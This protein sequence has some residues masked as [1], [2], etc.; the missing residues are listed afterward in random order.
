[1]SLTDYKLCANLDAVNAVLNEPED[2]DWLH[3]VR[4][5]KDL[6]TSNMI[7]TA[8]G[9][10]NIGFLAF[11]A[12]ALL[13]LF[14]G[15]PVLVFVN[16]LLGNSIFRNFFAQTEPID[17]SNIGPTWIMMKDAAGRPEKVTRS[18]LR[19][20]IDPDTPQSAMTRLS[21]DGTRR[22]K[23]VFSDEFNLDD[24]T[25]FEGDDP[26]WTA[27][28]LH[29]WGTSDYE[30]YTPLGATT[31]GGALRITLSEQPINNLNFKSAMLQ[32]W[33]KLCMQGGLLE[34]SLM[35][36]G[37]PKVPGYWPA[38]WTMS[39]LGR[40][41]FG[42]TNEGINYDSE[43]GPTARTVLPTADSPD[44]ETFGPAG[45][46]V[47][48]MPN[49][50]YLPE[51][52][53]GPLAAEMTG[54][55]V[56]TY[57]PALSFQPGQK[58]SRCTCAS[59]TDHPGPKHPD[60]S[61][62][63]RGASELDVLEATSG[64][65]GRN[66]MSLQTAPYNSGYNITPGYTRVYD[67]VNSLNTYTG[68]AYQ[69]AVSAMIQTP[70]TAYQHNGGEYAMYGV[71]W[72]PHYRQRDPYVTWLTANEPSWTLHAGALGP[73][74]LTEIGQRLIPPEPMYV[75]FNLG[76][77]SGFSAVKFDELKFPGIMSIDYVRIYQE[78]GQESLSCDGAH[79]EMPT[80]DY[81]KKHAEAY[82]NANLTIWRG[83]REDGAYGK[84]FPPHAMKGECE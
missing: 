22:L 57:G 32:S 76:I 68:A 78:E 47:G 39:N 81:I 24:R 8:R 28:D 7:F 6:R 19:G 69:Q 12:V 25:F 75:I 33:N 42:A 41:G 1:M 34:V 45:C 70:Q 60:G 63:G 23:L 83:K 37:D 67:S 71:E 9:C 16:K 52:K 73:D 56:E 58:L 29:Y 64:G 11:L 77:S 3:D 49:Q 21:A 54:V 27:V 66:S 82:W 80:V 10:M 36:P 15:W 51:G 62:Y 17:T 20:L 59:S 30:Y 40:A 4:D 74:N 26:F 53:G 5:P 55:Y 18:P 79:P 61:W 48:T 14:A 2:D 46:D 38:V 13:M 31:K 44:S 84:V 72:S 65:I 50:T 43:Q 35:L